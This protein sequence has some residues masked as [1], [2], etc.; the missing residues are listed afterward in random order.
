[1][2]CPACSAPPRNVPCPIHAR[3]DNLSDGS[4]LREVELSILAR[5]LFIAL[6]D[7]L[8]PKH[9]KSCTSCAQLLTEANREFSRMG[10]PVP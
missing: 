5:R 2:N 3:T 8:D 7:H 1:M 9:P 6:R 10:I 4:D